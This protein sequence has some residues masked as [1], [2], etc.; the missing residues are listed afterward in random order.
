VSRNLQ[1]AH[2]KF[3]WVIPAPRTVLAADNSRIV[4]QGTGTFEVKPGNPHVDGD[5][6]WA[7]FT[8]AG[9]L[10]GTGTFRVTDLTKFDLAPGVNPA[11]ATIRAGLAF[12]N[13]SYSDGAEG[14]L[15][16]SCHLVGTSDSVFEG[17]NASKGF[18]HYFNRVPPFGV[19]FR[20]LDD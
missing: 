4:I 17:V 14:I 5:G 18:V 20:A 8:P 2:P 16:V 7:T 3:A 9:V 6:T 15:I 10:T 19:F 12:L 1:A 13:I 11:D